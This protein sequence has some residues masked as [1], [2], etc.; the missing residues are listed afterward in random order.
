MK[1]EQ[2]RQCQEEST[3]RLEEENGTV[4]SLR[5]ESESIS[6]MERKMEKGTSERLELGRRNGIGEGPRRDHKGLRERSG[7]SREGRGETKSRS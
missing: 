5:E 4:R 7:A 6:V 1:G 2:E 3:A